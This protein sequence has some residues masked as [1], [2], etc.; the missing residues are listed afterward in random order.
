MKNK[1][2]YNFLTDVLVKLFP[3]RADISHILLKQT[4]NSVKAV[5]AMKD[6]SLIVNIESTKPIKEFDGVGCL[7]SIQYLHSILMSPAAKDSDEGELELTYDEINGKQVLSTIT[8]KG[9]HRYS[10]MYQLSNPDIKRISRVPQL[11]LQGEDWNTGF[12]ITEKLESKF[13]EMYRITRSM[14]K[15]TGEMEGVFTLVFDGVN[16]IEGIFGERSYES[17]IVLTDEAEPIKTGRLIAMFPIEKFRQ[18]VKLSPM[19]TT[20]IMLCDKAMMVDVVSELATY[21]YVLTAKKKRD[22]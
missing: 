10:A 21:S 14:P 3:F 6:G 4:G 13:E 20:I 15:S 9:A 17:S 18:I 22:I 2:L 12:A 16:T 19:D 8:V 7:G 5:A 11:K 1:E